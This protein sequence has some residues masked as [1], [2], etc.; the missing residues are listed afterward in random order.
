[1]AQDP[2]TID[3]EF[4]AA[5]RLI[6]KGPAPGVQ[7]KM[8][9]I[10]NEQKLKFYGLFKQATEGPNTTK[11]PSRL[12]V[13]KRY[14]WNAWKE[15]GSISKIDAKKKYVAMVSQVQ[16]DWKKLAGYVEVT[17]LSSFHQLLC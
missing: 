15:L 5:V 9:E 11:A 17:H 10:S 6:T 1:M 8:P 3:K 16:P 14:K 7:A 2:A 13:I 4:E 12:D